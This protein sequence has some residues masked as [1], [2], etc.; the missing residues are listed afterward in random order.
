MSTCEGSGGYVNVSVLSAIYGCRLAYSSG[1]WES[2]RNVKAKWPGGNTVKSGETGLSLWYQTI[3]P[4]LYLLPVITLWPNFSRGT[5]MHVDGCNI[6]YCEILAKNRT[7]EENHFFKV[8]W[9]QFPLIL[10][11]H[12]ER[13]K[14]RLS[15]NITW[16]KSWKK[17]S[18]I[19]FC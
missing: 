10:A 6:I 5:V 15:E 2:F 1:S 8:G 14:G 4:H 17:I 11:P 13:Q 16:N 12:S 18:I 3:N 19:F 7:A 9:S